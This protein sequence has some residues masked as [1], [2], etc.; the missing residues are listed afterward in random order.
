MRFHNGIARELYDNGSVK[1]EGKYFNGK[2]WNGKGYTYFG[3][4][5]YEIKNG[6]GYIT[7][8]NPDGTLLFKGN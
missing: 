6:K 1:F 2:R 8:Y 7:E 5:I 4:K 3:I